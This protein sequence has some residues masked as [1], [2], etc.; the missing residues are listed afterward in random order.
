IGYFAAEDM[1]Y[2]RELWRTD[3]TPA[4]TG[5]ALDLMPGADGAGVDAP[6][7]RETSMGS[8]MAVMNGALYFRGDDGSHG[9]ELWKTDGTEPG[10]VLVADTLPGADGIAPAW[11][12]E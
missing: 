11:L 9:V 2:G 10:T 8:L 1:A 12:T 6:A 4:G 7:G 5:R 3:G